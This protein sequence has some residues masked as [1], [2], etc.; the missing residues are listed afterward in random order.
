ML[1]SDVPHA[2][3]CFLQVTGF[4]TAPGATSQAELLQVLAI[5]GSLAAAED[6]QTLMAVASHLPPTVL[7]DVVM[8]NM[9]NLSGMRPGK[10]AVQSGN[11][12]SQAT[13]IA[14]VCVVTLTSDHVDC[15]IFTKRARSL[16]STWAQHAMLFNAG[17]TFDSQAGSACHAVQCRIHV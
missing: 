10:Q 7:A 14:Q 6:Q 4:L 12:A 5:L 3:P 8:C 13:A 2:G 11:A 16:E 17:S 9:A 15:N 1:L